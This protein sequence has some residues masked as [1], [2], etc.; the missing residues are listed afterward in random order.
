MKNYISVLVALLA[1]IGFTNCTNAPNNADEETT[2]A[3][4]AP[5][6]DA[7]TV[8]TYSTSKFGGT[9]SFGDDAEKGTVGHLYVFPESDSSLLFY[10][11][12]NKGAPSY[13]M[14]IL[15]GRMVMMNGVA[16]Y[17]KKE[18]Y[19]EKGCKLQFSFQDNA[20]IVTTVKGFEE[21]EFGNGV[22][23]DNNYAKKGSDVPAFFINAEGDTIQF[24]SAKPEN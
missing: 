9:Y 13:N 1:I 16:T 24:S 21:C 19:Q 23:V 3:A 2:E 20:V 8:A 7:G 18:D 4:T 5:A 22:V 10:L 14:G 6:S 15:L 11:D 17:F 12:V